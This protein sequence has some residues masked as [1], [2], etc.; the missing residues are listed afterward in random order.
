ML[1]MLAG[2]GIGSHNL[3]R[4]EAPHSRL[5][6]AIKSRSLQVER[7]RCGAALQMGSI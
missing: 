6:Q 3:E 4:A 1:M 7:F 5:N 2:D